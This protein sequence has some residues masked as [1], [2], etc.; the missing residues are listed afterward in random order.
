MLISSHGY[1]AT[2]ISVYISLKSLLS[3]SCPATLL[4][5]GT[6]PFK[7]N[8]SG[9]WTMSLS[10]FVY[11]FS[12]IYASSIYYISYD[13]S[14]PNLL[15][16][17]WGFK[18]QISG[19]LKGTYGH[20]HFVRTQP[21]LCHLMERVKRKSSD[22]SSK[23]GRSFGDVKMLPFRANTSYPACDLFDEATLSSVLPASFPTPPIDIF[24]PSLC[25]ADSVPEYNLSRLL[26]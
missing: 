14:E 24:F 9:S 15:V 2:I 21:N 3:I 8:V 4:K 20:V 12:N 11:G 26:S 13:V 18:R 23:R 22:K 6:S 25:D 5:Q 16:N 10:H 17:I 19:A 7:D 1:R